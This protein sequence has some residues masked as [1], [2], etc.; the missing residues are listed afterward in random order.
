VDRPTLAA[1]LP[2]RNGAKTLPRLLA[3]VRP[4]VDEVCILDTGST[5]GTLELLT[6]AASEPGAPIHVQCDRWRDDYAWARNASFGMASSDYVIWFDDDEILEGGENLHDFLHGVAYVRRIEVGNPGGWFG[7]R[8]APRGLGEWRGRIHEQL[9]VPVDT[10]ATVVSPGVLQVLHHPLPALDRHDH[11]EAV[12]TG[13]EREPSRS[14]L[15]LAAGELANHNDHAT[16]S[17]LIEYALDPRTPLPPNEPAGPFADIG[18]LG[19]LRRLAESRRILGDHD[20]ADWALLQRRVAALDL[21][22]CNA[23]F[24]TAWN[25]AIEYP[26]PTGARDRKSLAVTA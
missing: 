21:R 26:E 16:A 6:Q 8:I 24:A 9:H 19:A 4:R 22:R 5:D 25:Y 3:S 15:L 23:L 13:L 11:L 17:S 12:L 2:V 7:L 10:P 14:F 1:C 20:G 18:V